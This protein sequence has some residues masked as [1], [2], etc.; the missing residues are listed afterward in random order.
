VIDTACWRFGNLLQAGT[1]FVG[2]NVLFLL[3][4]QFAYLN[5]VLAF[6][7]IF[8]GC[9]IGKMYREKLGITDGTILE[10]NPAG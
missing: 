1:V 6:L 8:L 3:P 4:R 7:L 5:V 2:Q 10:S 9:Y